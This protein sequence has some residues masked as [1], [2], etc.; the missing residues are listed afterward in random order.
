MQIA[1][2]VCTSNPHI[3]ISFQN[4]QKQAGFADCGLFSIAFAT[5]LVFGKRPE[6]YYFNQ[7]EM[8]FHL[9]RCFEKRKM[10]LFPTVRERKLRG[11]LITKTDIIEVYCI[12]RMPEL[13]GSQWIE[14]SKCNEWY[15]TGTCVTVTPSCWKKK[16]HGFVAIVEAKLANE[17]GCYFVF[18]LHSFTV[19]VLFLCCAFSYHQWQ[20]KTSCFVSFVAWYHWTTKRTI[21]SNYTCKCSL[22]GR[23]K[24]GRVGPKHAARFGPR[25]KSGKLFSA[26]KNKTGSAFL[27]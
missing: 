13:T 12:C 1:N 8:R 23:T 4:V 5:A 6:N 26:R 20:W 25:T 7:N 16:S 22:V 2:I 18:I 24:I 11:N 3:T 17:F 9:L 27:S 14:C 19:F 15:H 10:E 21:G